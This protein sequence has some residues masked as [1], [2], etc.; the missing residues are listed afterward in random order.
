MVILITL[1]KG[2][3]PG[4]AYVKKGRRKT[5]H[6]RER[7]SLEEP[8]RGAEIQRKTLRHGKNLAFNDEAC[9][10]NERVRSKMTPKKVE[11]GLKRRFELSK[12]RLG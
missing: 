7:D 11:V 4:E 12:R 3:H 8:H 5:L 9:L 6:S 2:N 1:R 10:E